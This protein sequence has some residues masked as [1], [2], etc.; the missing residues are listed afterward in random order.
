[1]REQTAVAWR[2]CVTGE[3]EAGF[4]RVNK[5]TPCGEYRLVSKYIQIDINKADQRNRIFKYQ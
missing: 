5:F 1:M 3:C 2:C 4:M